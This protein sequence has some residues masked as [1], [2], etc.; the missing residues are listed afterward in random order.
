MSH[1]ESDIYIVLP[2]WMRR[3]LSLMVDNCIASGLVWLPFAFACLIASAHIVD[4]VH[5]FTVLSL[6]PFPI[7]YFRFF[8]K[9]AHNMPTPGEALSRLHVVQAIYPRRSVLIECIYALWQWRAFVGVLVVCAI[10]YT[11]LTASQQPIY[12][13]LFA[14]NATV[15]GS[16]LMYL[17]FGEPP[18]RMSE[19]V[20][21]D[22]ARKSLVI[23]RTDPVALLAQRRMMKGD[24]IHL[25]R[26]DKWVEG[27]LAFFGFCFDMGMS[28]A[29]LYL[30]CALP[31]VSGFAYYLL[32]AC[33]SMPYMLYCDFCRRHLDGYTLGEMLFRPRST[34][35]YWSPLNTTFLQ[36]YGF[37]LIE[38]ID[39]WVCSIIV[40]LIMQ[41]QLHWQ[42]LPCV[43]LVLAV[44]A[45]GGMVFMCG[46]QGRDRDHIDTKRTA[47]EL[48]VS[49]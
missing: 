40:Y 42:S 29:P 27:C 5:I 23:N 37:S 1:S 22:G 19:T 30:L 39:F 31:L 28:Y 7:I 24:R 25:D 26:L 47:L 21:H 34:M 43:M 3:A 32:L 14:I 41:T 45:M 38:T 2:L 12:V 13:I 11:S 20:V 9:V 48:P 44:I 18:R 8:F 35:A 33:M 49:V 46:R 16:F 4:L 10:G 6:S 36:R 17:L 15:G